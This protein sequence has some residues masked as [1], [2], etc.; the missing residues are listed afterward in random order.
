MRD[1]AGQLSERLHLRPLPHR[2]FRGRAIGDV[3]EGDE[4][5]IEA[6][7]RFQHRCRAHLRMEVAAVGATA[8]Q[9]LAID[10]L[11]M[12]GAIGRVLAIDIV[13]AV[14]MHGAQRFRR[15]E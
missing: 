4:R 9:A 13:P 8:D 6:A 1:P 3:G 15:R 11:A 12:S 10:P 14:G 5:L 2:F 7:L